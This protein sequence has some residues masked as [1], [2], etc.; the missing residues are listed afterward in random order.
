MLFRSYP[1]IFADQVLMAAKVYNNAFLVPEQCPQGHILIRRLLDAGYLNVYVNTLHDSRSNPNAWMQK[2][3]YV[4]SRAAKS[5]LFHELFSATRS[6][7]TVY[8]RRFL[9][10]TQTFIEKSPGV[11]DHMTNQH[12]D[13]IVALALAVHGHLALS[14][15]TPLPIEQQV[16]PSFNPIGF[17]K[18]LERFADPRYA[19]K[20]RRGAR[21]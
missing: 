3:G 19:G 20:R 6:G 12:S 17:D 14:P 21:R 16:A 5:V 13:A 15:P 18:A 10:E 4:T 2:Y 1:D 9:L 7:L 8:S 11:Y